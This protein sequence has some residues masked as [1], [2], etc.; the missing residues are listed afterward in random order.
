MGKLKQVT[1]QENFKE[2]KTEKTEIMSS[3]SLHF[4]KKKRVY[5]VGMPVTTKMKKVLS[6]SL[7]NTDC[8]SKQPLSPLMSL[9]YFQNPYNKL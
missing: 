8:L 7:L 5:A 3:K 6:Y 9:H 2:Q 1:Q 4:K